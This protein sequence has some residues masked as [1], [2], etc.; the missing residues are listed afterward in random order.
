MDMSLMTLLSVGLLVSQVL[1][2]PSSEGEVRPTLTVEPFDGQVYAQDTVTLTCQLPGHPGW[3]LFWYKDRQETTP[4]QVRDCAGGESSAVYRL[5]RSSLSHT[6]QYWCR[7]GK[8]KPVHFTEYSEPVYVSVIE[9]FTSV[10]LVASPSRVVKEGGALN[11]TCQAVVNDPYHGHNDWL[12]MVVKFSFL[13][14]GRPVGQESDMMMYS[15]ARTQTSHAGSY[16]CVARVGKVRERSPDTLISLDNL[17]LHLVICFGSVLLVSV[18]PLAFLLRR[19]GPRRKW[20][21]GGSDAGDRR[22]RCGAESRVQRSSQER[23]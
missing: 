12:P 4:V 21:C 15:I 6:G 13:Q 18:A 23:G 8:G 17:T 10:T 9:L 5:W 11:L 1:S 2:C 3:T 7:A 16:S 14:N 19:Y 22:K 20:Q